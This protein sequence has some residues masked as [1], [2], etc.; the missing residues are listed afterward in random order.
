M[1][2]LLPLSVLFAVQAR[3]YRRSQFATEETVFEDLET[4]K[5]LSIP[6]TVQDSNV[7]S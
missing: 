7:P 3:V 1:G 2:T 4:A 5:E 6:M